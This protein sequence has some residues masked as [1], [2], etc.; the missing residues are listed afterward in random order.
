ESMAFDQH[1]VEPIP[2]PEQLDEKLSAQAAELEQ[3][4]KDNMILASSQKNL[5]QSVASARVEADRLR[6]R[7]RSVQTEGDIEIRIKLD[8][9]SKLEADI[10]SGDA[11]KKELREAQKE[12]QSL[13]TAKTELTAKIEQATKELDAARSNIKKIPGMH[14]QLD[15]LRQEN[16]RLRNTFE[17]EKSLNMEKVEQMKKLEKKIVFAAGEVERLRAQL[18]DAE[19]RFPG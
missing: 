11:I 1:S 13:K 19:K 15:N 10:R 9:Y 3:L 8:K 7:I 18:S 16:I 17:Y 14:V 5:V 4:L 12:A 6:E 2:P